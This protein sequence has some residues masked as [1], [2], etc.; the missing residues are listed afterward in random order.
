MYTC[1]YIHTYIH[2]YIHRGLCTQ[3][4]IFALISILCVYECRDFSDGTRRYGVPAPFPNYEIEK[5]LLLSEYDK[6]EF[7]MLHLHTPRFVKT[8]KN[9]NSYK[10]LK[11]DF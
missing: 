7:L 8:L 2:T 11:L 6:I 9:L 4:C 3:V 5:L 1:I 10:F